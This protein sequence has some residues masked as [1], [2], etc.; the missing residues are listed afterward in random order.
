MRSMKLYYPPGL[1]ALTS[2]RPGAASRRARQVCCGSVV[3]S[4]PLPELLLAQAALSYAGALKVGA[5]SL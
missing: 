2:R 1:P 5:S 3:T 4:F